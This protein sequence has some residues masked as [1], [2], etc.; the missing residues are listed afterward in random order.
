[1]AMEGHAGVL[2]AIWR[3]KEDHRQRIGALEQERKRLL[4]Q[5]EAQ[6]SDALAELDDTESESFGAAE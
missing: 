4:E 2:E 3:F 5:L 6:F 1:M